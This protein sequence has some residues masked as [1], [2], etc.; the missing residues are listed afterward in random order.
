MVEIAQ[1]GKIFA[2][3]IIAAQLVAIILGPVLSSTAIII[4][5]DVCRIHLIGL[6]V[7]RV[8]LCREIHPIG[9]IS[10]VVY[11]NVCNC[12]QALILESV[13]HRF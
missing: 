6:T 7:I 12:Q 3:I 1:S 8:G 11:H 10:A 4:S 2:C 5:N 13:Y 9:D